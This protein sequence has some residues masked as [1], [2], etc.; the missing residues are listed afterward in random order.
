MPYHAAMTAE[1]RR[2]IAGLVVGTC[3]LAS[4][5]S[6]TSPR[7]G[8]STTAANP[9]TGEP[10]ANYGDSGGD[11]ATVT[12]DSQP[13]V[14]PGQVPNPIAQ[15]CLAH[16]SSVN[17][18]SA[19][20]LNRT[21]FREVDGALTL[22]SKRPVEA[23]I[24]FGASSFGKTLFE[25]SFVQVTA[26]GPVCSGTTSLTWSTVSPG[27]TVHFVIWLIYPNVITASQANGNPAAIDAAH[28]NIPSVF[29]AGAT[30]PIS[31]VTGAGLT[32]TL[33]FPGGHVVNTTSK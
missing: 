23:G 28:W 4:C 1:G 22:T 24:R 17:A 32:K 31:S 27:Q 5:S 30:A 16:D 6:P 7:A 9:T 10:T 21:L 33:Y 2:I 18:D 20:L 8:T 26:S 25:Q 13:L 11:R 3:I 14:Q 15:A 29:L 19:D 12:L